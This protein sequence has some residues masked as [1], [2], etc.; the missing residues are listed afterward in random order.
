MGAMN[1][2]DRVCVRLTGDLRAKLEARVAESGLSA[3]EVVRT[4]LEAS[5]RESGEDRGA[6]VEIAAMKQGVLRGMAVVDRRIAQTLREVLS[7][8][9]EGVDHA[10]G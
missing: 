2:S 5:L 1:V 4:L 6:V 7:E 8:L 10:K 3:S 9:G